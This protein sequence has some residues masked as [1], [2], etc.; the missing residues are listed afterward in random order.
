MLKNPLQYFNSNKKDKL[1]KICLHGVSKLLT[2]FNCI[3]WVTMVKILYQ[4]EELNAKKQTK[5]PT[6]W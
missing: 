3:F 1:Q 4:S 2:T 6:I 5:K